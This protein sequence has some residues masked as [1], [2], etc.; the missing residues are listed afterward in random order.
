MGG[1][2]KEITER[3]QSKSALAPSRSQESTHLTR[4]VN[5]VLVTH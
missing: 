2:R 3:G 4:R 5:T 1:V